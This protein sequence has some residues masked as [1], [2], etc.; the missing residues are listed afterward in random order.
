MRHILSESP[1]CQWKVTAEI[2]NA[3]AIGLYERHGFVQERTF[4]PAP[5]ITMVQL[6]RRSG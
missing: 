5:G 3:P 6:G 2:R 1:G 4:R